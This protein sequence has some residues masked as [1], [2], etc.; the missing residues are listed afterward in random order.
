MTRSDELVDPL[1]QAASVE[2][3]PIAAQTT[4]KRYVQEGMDVLNEHVS[5][6]EWKIPCPRGQWCIYRCDE[7]KI[8]Y[9]TGDPYSSTSGPN[10]PSKALFVA[11]PIATMRRVPNQ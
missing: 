7:H 9:K 2:D 1:D 8:V 6:L 10:S 11:S 3:N 4:T 5:A